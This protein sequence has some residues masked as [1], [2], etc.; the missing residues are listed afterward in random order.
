MF[1]IHST[2]DGRTPPTEYLPAVAGTHSIG[3]VLA[4]ENGVLT[5]VSDGGGTADGRHYVSVAEKNCGEGELLP[6]VAG[7][8]DVIFDVTL[9]AEIETIAPGAVCTLSA[10]G[11]LKAVAE[12]GAFIVLE[13]EGTDVGAVQRGILL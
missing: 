13:S 1:K 5:P 7:G 6:V 12:G 3:E 11:S 10:D 8:E 4:F 9:T 2:R